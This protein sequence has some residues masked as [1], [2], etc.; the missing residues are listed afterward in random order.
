MLGHHG[1]V[2]LVRAA[3]VVITS[4]KA[5]GRVPYG[6]GF[7]VAPGWVLSCAHVVAKATRPRVLWRGSE[8]TPIEKHVLP[9]AADADERFGFPDAALLKV[10]VPGPEQ[11]ICVPIGTDLP[12]PG[13]EVWAYGMNRVRTGRPEP[14][15]SRLTVANARAGQFIRVQQ[16]QL[17]P[18]MSGGPVLN[19]GTYEVFGMAKAT[20]GRDTELGGWI[21]PIADAL[22]IV[23]EPLAQRNA[24]FHADTLRAV[25]NGQAM[26][27]RLPD[28]VLAQLLSHEGAVSLLANRLGPPPTVAAADIP[29]WVARRLFCLTLDDLAAA[30]LAARGALDPESIIFIFDHVACSLA[31]NRPLAWWVPGDAA[32]LV[33]V[34]SAADE[35]RVLRVGTDEEVTLGLLLRR[36]VEDDTWEVKKPG[37]PSSAARAEPRR[38][39]DELVRDVRTEI[40]RCLGA[41]ER[42]W[43]KFR[44]AFRQ[45]LRTQNVYLQV[46]VDGDPDTAFLS[47]LRTEFQGFRILIRKRDVV[48]PDGADDILL[49]VVPA[50]DADGE[51]WGLNSRKDLLEQIGLP[52]DHRV[53]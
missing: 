4:E 45:R 41:G 35:P 44:D 2:E 22:A 6:S 24:E 15:G 34:E 26:L 25:R 17:A 28:R 20:Q 12:S 14:D 49:D 42:E 19:L 16:G 27:G 39:P 18:G 38:P 53:T 30:L 1:I 23:A 8:L 36:A 10:E 50:I 32:H 37:G 7:F 11:E 31:M 13:E 5:G 9:A 51:W 21:T 29:E 43:Q 40:L 46:R 47:A 52:T 48:L 33:R 3:T